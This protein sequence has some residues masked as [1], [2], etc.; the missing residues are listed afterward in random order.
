[1]FK[2]RF[3]LISLHNRT[4]TFL[5]FSVIN[6]NDPGRDYSEKLPSVDRGDRRF[7]R[8]VKNSLF[9]GVGILVLWLV[10]RNQDYEL[11]KGKVLGASFI[12]IVSSRLFTV[13]GTVIRAARWQLLLAPV[14]DKPGLQNTFYATMTGYLFNLVLPRMGEFY[15]CW[16]LRNTDN[17]PV[18]KSLGTVVSERIM[19]TLVLVMMTAFVFITRIALVGAYFEEVIFTPLTKRIENLID[20]P[21][22]ITATALFIVII[23]ATGSIMLKRL[24]L[25]ETGS[26]IN[27]AMKG[28]KHGLTSIWKMEQKWLFL[29]LTAA[30]WGC[31]LLAAYSTFFAFEATSGLTLNDALMVLSMASIGMAA[32][33]QGG[34]GTYHGA[35]SQ[36]LILLGVS[37]EAGAAYV[38]LVHA[39]ITLLSVFAG[40]FSLL[41]VWLK[42]NK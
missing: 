4:K 12:I 6:T 38:L 31:Y 21:F 39:A 17:I 15:R 42:S 14:G 37:A 40:S 24:R 1:M 18:N 19:D 30:M 36:G 2:K 5:Q 11:L 34:I 23:I 32:P 7:L 22:W 3:D 35:V 13:A 28:F 10:L 27:N 41:M 9:F 33:V 16:A 26:K 29:G 8:F 20:R 25:T